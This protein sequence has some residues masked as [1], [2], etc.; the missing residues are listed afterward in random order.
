MSIEAMD[1]DDF[2]ERVQNDKELF[3]ELI[4]IFIVDFHKKRKALEEAIHTKDHETLEHVSHFLR[5]SCGNISAGSLG[6][7]FSKLEIKG[8]EN[9]LE[10]TEKYLPEIDQKFEELTKYIGE[11][12][13][14]L[15]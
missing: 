4:D 7:I 8:K 9:D 6:V 14:K 1:V 10:D 3:F 2:M 11:I 5:G 15:S 13:V 12:R